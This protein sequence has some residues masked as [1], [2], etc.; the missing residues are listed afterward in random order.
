[1]GVPAAAPVSRTVPAPFPA[2][3]RHR[4]ALEESVRSGMQMRAV[5]R[6]TLALGGHV[7]ARRRTGELVFSHPEVRPV[8]VHAHQGSAPRHLTV[9]LKR[10]QE[11]LRRQSVGGR[12]HG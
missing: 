12:W 8:V 2:P 7:K 11:H 1:M 6:L 10:L 5:A 4:R 9:W 3:S